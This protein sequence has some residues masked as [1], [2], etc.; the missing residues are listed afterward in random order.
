[1]NSDLRNQII[2]DHMGKMVHVVVDRPIGYRHGDITYPINY[3]YL[4][5]V[6]ALDREEQDVYI[7]GVSKPIEEFDGRVIAA[8]RR[9][10]D[11]EDKL[12]VAPDGVMYHQAEIME[13]VFFQERFFKSSV[14]SLFH[15]SCGVIPFRFRGNEKEYLILLQRNNCWS[16]PKGHME[17]G[18][19]EEQT[20]L[21]ELREEAGLC[22][23]LFPDRKTVLEYDIS[24]GM[25]KQVV[26]FMGEVEG[27]VI[28]QQTEIVRHAW[29]SAKE[30]KVYIHPETY[31]AC[32]ELLR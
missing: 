2:A 20:A 24:C 32:E 7:L 27:C 17:P 4:S 26:L 21:R 9:E 13:A 29:V 6:A 23:R 18:E 25:K 5:G 12:V 30:L 8:I 11:L 31:K 28:L 19:T 10:D 15:K 16:F 1:M 14:D 22:A 3:G